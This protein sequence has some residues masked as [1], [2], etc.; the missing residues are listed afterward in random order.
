[1]RVPMKR[2][3]PVQNLVRIRKCSKIFIEV[4]LLFTNISFTVLVLVPNHLLFRDTLLLTSQLVGTGYPRILFSYGF[5][6]VRWLLCIK[7]VLPVVLCRS[8]PVT[9]WTRR[10]ILSKIHDFA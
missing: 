5:H 8:S 9:Q 7:H 6:K 1:M 3:N 2:F 10:L 4:V